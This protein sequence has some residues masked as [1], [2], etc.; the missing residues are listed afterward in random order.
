MS[1]AIGLGTCVVVVISPG[2]ALTKNRLI[3]NEPFLF[4]VSSYRKKWENSLCS[5]VCRKKVSF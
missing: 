5:V 1:R 4:E 2:Q 3:A